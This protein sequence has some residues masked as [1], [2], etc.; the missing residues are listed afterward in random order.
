MNGALI[1]LLMYLLVNYQG[2][3]GL[4]AGDAAC[5]QRRADNANGGV[6]LTV[7]ESG[8]VNG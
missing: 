7:V 1:A 8:S 2:A 6:C 3:T 5:W 4:Y